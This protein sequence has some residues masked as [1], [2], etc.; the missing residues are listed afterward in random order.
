MST[1]R[2]GGII[3]E[4]DYTGRKL[5]DAKKYAEDGGF[6]VRI[7]EQDGVSKMLD[8]SIRPDRI[9]FIVRRGI[10]ISAFGG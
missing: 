10:V 7:V 4:S 9:N 8:M 1:L 3:T 5:A 6:T 2:N